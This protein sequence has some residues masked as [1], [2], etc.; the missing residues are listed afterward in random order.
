MVKN[1]IPPKQGVK[2]GFFAFTG[3]PLLHF[4]PCFHAIYSDKKLYQ[5]KIVPPKRTTNCSLTIF[6]KNNYTTRFIYSKTLYIMIICPRAVT[7]I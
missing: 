7:N 1:T 5:A 2:N 4:L 3:H 6:I